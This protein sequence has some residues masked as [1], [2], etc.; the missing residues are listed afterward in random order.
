[1]RLL[2]SA[3]TAGGT[4]LARL[5][6]LAFRCLHILLSPFKQALY[7]DLRVLRSRQDNKILDAVIGPN[8]IDMVHTFLGIKKPAQL[9]FH[10]KAVLK[11]VV[12]AAAV[13]MLWFVNPNIARA[14][15][16]APTLPFVAVGTLFGVV[17]PD[18]AM[19]LP[20]GF[21]STWPTPYIFRRDLPTAAL[22]LPGR[23]GR[24]DSR[25]QVLIHPF[26]SGRSRIV[27][28]HKPLAFVR[29]LAATASAKTVTRHGMSPFNV[30]FYHD[31]ND[32]TT[33]QGGH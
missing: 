25:S 9:L 13:W 19:I 14:I 1:M 33:T 17:P 23:V 10:N 29:H 27:S 24:R 22:T 4:F 5:G 30:E 2:F 18:E 15:D 6:N 3:P 20:A 12:S 32:L 21:A 8:S 26:G 31:R 11:Y 7:M 28:P 16:H